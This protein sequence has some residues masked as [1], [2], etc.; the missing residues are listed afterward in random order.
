MQFPT[1]IS[2]APQTWD[3]A[4]KCAG[5]SPPHHH[6]HPRLALA[7]AGL[8]LAGGA[9]YTWLLIDR[10]VQQMQRLERELTSL[11]DTVQTM[12]ATVDSR[13]HG[14]HVDLTRE[15]GSVR[16]IQDEMHVL[17]HSVDTYVGSDIPRMVQRIHSEAR[18]ACGWRGASNTCI[19]GAGG[20]G[21]CAGGVCRAQAASVG[22]PTWSQ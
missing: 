20:W 21:H 14:L 17:S 19:Q 10:L 8:L 3:G 5:A 18:C 11:H 22:F 4:V 16:S 6:T 1:T 9:A 7:I 15:L 13:V 12:G 2:I